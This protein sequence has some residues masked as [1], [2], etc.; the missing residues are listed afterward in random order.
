MI[1]LH[2]FI[3]ESNKVPNDTVLYDLNNIVDGEDVITCI[4]PHIYS[5]RT[6]NGGDR[7]YIASFALKESKGTR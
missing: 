1:F 2:T 7:E 4:A 3:H 6:F 5:Q